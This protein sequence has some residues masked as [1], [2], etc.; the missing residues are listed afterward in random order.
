M[1][2]TNRDMQINQQG[3][4]MQ[5]NKNSLAQCNKNRQARWWDSNPK[6][7]TQGR[8]EAEIKSLLC[9]DCI[10]IIIK[11]LMTF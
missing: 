11:T 9:V 6:T 4:H 1:I 10:N 2:I 5:C 3:H 8:Q 7:G